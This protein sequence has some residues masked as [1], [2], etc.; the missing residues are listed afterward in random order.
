MVDFVDEARDE[1]LFPP[2]A[3]VLDVGEFAWKEV[4][5][6]LPTLCL[7]ALGLLG[8]GNGHLLFELLELAPPFTEATRMLGVD[9]SSP[10]IELCN[11]I[12]RGKGDEASQVQFAVMDFLADTEQLEKQRW[13]L[14]CDKGTVSA[15]PGGAIV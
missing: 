9:Y 15:R 3:S 11:R 8:T 10:S 6:W 14:V 5:N 12:A 1:G 4:L 2:S 7:Y 13:D